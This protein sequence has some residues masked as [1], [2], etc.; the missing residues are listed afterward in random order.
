[1]SELEARFARLG[2]GSDSIAKQ[3]E[4]KQVHRQPRTPTGVFIRGEPTCE[5]CSTGVLC[6]PTGYPEWKRDQEV[7]GRRRSQA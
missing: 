6:L 2:E 3:R 1:M 4:S 7:S 5:I